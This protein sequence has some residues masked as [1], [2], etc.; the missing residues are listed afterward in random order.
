MKIN[1]SD[2]RENVEQIIGEGIIDGEEMDVTA[3]KIMTLVWPIIDYF[4]TKEKLT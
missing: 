4:Q 3:E 1:K 2:L